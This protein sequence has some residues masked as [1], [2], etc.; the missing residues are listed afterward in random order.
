[1]A[2]LL[3]VAFR[4]FSKNIFGNSDNAIL[5]KIIAFFIADI[6]Y[7][8]CSLSRI[9]ETISSHFN[10]ENTEILQILYVII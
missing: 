8:I 4:Y 3:L 10:I 5:N 2:I 9:R 7:N 6:T 1:M